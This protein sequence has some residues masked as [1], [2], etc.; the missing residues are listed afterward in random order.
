[1]SQ[2][3]RGLVFDA[4]G[5]LLDVESVASACEAHFPGQGLAL[6]RLWRQ[7]QLEYSWLRS[8]MGRHADFWQ[9]TADA[10]DYACA[11]LGLEADKATRSALRDSYL[12]LAPFPEVPAALRR[13]AAYRRLVLS[14]GTEQMLRAALGLAGLLPELEAVL[15]VESVGC[16]KPAPQVYALATTQLGCKP[17][18]AL[19]VSSNGW[20]VAGATHF[21]FQTC[22]LNRAGAPAEQLGVAPTLTARNL[23]EL[24]ERL[25]SAAQRI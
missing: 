9:L 18:Q 2:Q 6:T 8:L 24:A 25:Q 23:A 4:Y 13:L 19:F 7:R 21:G 12:R 15:S 20:D 17:G 5:T 1:M 14:N 16:Y 10:L 3:Y 22:W 11:A